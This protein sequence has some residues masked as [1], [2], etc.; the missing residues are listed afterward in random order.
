MK[1]KID[2]SIDNVNKICSICDAYD[3]DVNIVCGIKCVDGKSTLG[4]MEMCNHTVEVIPV[5]H[6]YH[7]VSEFFTRL[8]EV[9]AYLEEEE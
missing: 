1:I 7:K 6:D 4:V 3:F 2:V 9:G 5:T 8:E